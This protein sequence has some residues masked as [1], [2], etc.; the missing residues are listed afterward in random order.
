[1]PSRRRGRGSLRR[2]SPYLEVRRRLVVFCEGSVTEPGYLKSLERLHGPQNIATFDILEV[3]LPPR[4]LVE[5]AKIAK[6]EAEDS[7]EG[8]TEY[9]CVFDVEAPTP[10][11]LIRDAVV[12]ARDNGI[13]VAVS[14]PC[15]ELWLLLHYADRTGWLTTAE[16][17]ALRGQYD[18]ST[19]KGLD[20]DGYVRRRAE[21]VARARKLEA[22]HRS[23]IT[24]FPH[25]N[26]SSGMF[27]LAEAV[28][29]PIQVA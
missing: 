20:G 17:V 14:N 29:P 13:R 26:P 25:D 21:A 10:H 16:A 6:A 12:M 15:F 5:K 7:A 23:D 9:W 24:D 11:P 3:G 1:M 19:G 28:E 22:M 4:K 8:D 2:R 27:K 18:G